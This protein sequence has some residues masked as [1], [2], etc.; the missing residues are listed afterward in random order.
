M[1][2]H[3][4]EVLEDRKAVAAVA[5]REGALEAIHGKLAPGVENWTPCTVL[6]QDPVVNM[7]WVRM[8]MTEMFQPF[9]A[10][11]ERIEFMEGTEI[12]GGFDLKGEAE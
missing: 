7:N 1:D 10:K 5:A 4:V 8:A 6:L 3:G 11:V 9:T 2:F 12:I